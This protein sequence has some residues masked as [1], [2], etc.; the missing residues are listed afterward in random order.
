MCFCLSHV[1][2]LSNR[3][4]FLFIYEAARTEP[5]LE[6]LSFPGCWVLRFMAHPQS[7]HCPQC[8]HYISE[9]DE[10]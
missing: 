7:T 4:Q 10:C 1:A 8:L 9:V 5:S 6:L 3:R 2:R